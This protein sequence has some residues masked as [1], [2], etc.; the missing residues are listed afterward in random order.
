MKQ[1]LILILVILVFISC[2]C[3]QQAKG[4]VLDRETK[5]P[6]EDVFIYKY[7]NDNSNSPLKLSYT[8]EDGQFEYHSIS[9]GFRHCPDLTLSFKK[10][11]YKISEITFASV[12]VNDTILLEKIPINIDSSLPISTLEFE[13]QIEKCITNLKTKKLKDISDDQHIEIMMCLNTIFVRNF[14]GKIY[15][16]LKTLVDEKKYTSEII[17]VYPKWIPNRG[18]GFYFQDLKMEL[19]GTPMPYAVYNVGK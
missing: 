8:N 9:G 7:K 3:L 5:R 16:K 1:L 19:Y 12:S 15:N 6:I 14:N 11:G 18:M 2:D 4:I 13:K 10:R 17:K